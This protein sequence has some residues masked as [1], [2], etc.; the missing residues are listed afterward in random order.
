MI[1]LKTV[2]YVAALARVRLT[3]E[4]SETFAAQL[5]KILAYF[6]LLQKIDTKGIEPTS[7]V[8]PLQNV[9]KE[10]TPQRSLVQEE[11]LSMAPKRQ[12]PFVKVQRV[13]ET[14]GT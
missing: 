10:D 3:Q 4:E 1:D 11:V 14:Q 9:F 5:S 7:H 12:G 2:Q 8:I 13:I 6:E